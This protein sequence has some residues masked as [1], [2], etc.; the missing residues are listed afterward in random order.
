MMIRNIALALPITA[1]MFA[2]SCGTRTNTDDDS[3]STAP[4]ALAA[5]TYSEAYRPAFHFTP[6]NGWM[7]DPNGLIYHNGEYHLFYQYY[8]DDTVWGPMHWAHAVSSDLVHWEN[9]PIAL[10]PDEKGYI[11]S[12][13]AVFDEHNTSGLGPPETSPLIAIFTYHD[14]IRGAENT[15]DHE[16]QAIAYSLDDGR[17]WI[18]YEGNPVLPNPGGKKDFRDPNV[19]WHDETQRW[20]MVVSVFDHVEIYSSPNLIN[21]DFLSDFGYNFGAMNGTWECPDLFPIQIDETGETRWVLIQNLNPGGPQ[22][23][24]GTQYFIGDFDGSEFTLDPEFES[25]LDR[26]G[27]H[28]A[29]WGRDNYAGITWFGAPDDRRLFIGWMSNWDYAQQVPTDT[30]R[31]AMT[32]PRDLSLTFGTEEGYVLRSRPAPELSKLRASGGENVT[33]AALSEHGAVL[34]GPSEITISMPA[35]AASGEIKIV[36][37]NASD[38]KYIFSLSADGKTFSSDRTQAGPAGFSETF[39]DRTHRAPRLS[40]S[41]VLTLEIFVDAS[42]FEIFAD[43]GATVMTETVF[44]TTALDRLSISSTTSNVQNTEIALYELRNIW[45]N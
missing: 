33:D 20:M 18:K 21:W 30:W 35:N 6:P 9:L 44:P 42:S 36:F 25:Q 26:N 13:S 4:N 5:G 31:S 14:P 43:D 19:F 7:N 17:T 40:V 16:S 2:S 37:S 34:N 11:F 22:G 32:I 45:Q 38:E 10:Y 28:W 8:P 24:S 41:D 12:G 29:D 27:P 15:L 3:N 23:G 39:A 1:L